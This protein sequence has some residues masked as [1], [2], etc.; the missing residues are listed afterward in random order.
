MKRCPTH[1][2]YKGIR[3]STRDCDSCTFVYLFAE[4]ERLK[5]RIAYLERQLEQQ[6]QVYY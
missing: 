5:R 1:R 6:R 4:N 2:S 3:M